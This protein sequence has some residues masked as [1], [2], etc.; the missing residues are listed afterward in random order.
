ARDQ[1]RVSG[2]FPLGA[3]E[4]WVSTW[5]RASRALAVHPGL[6]AKRRDLLL[7]RQVVADL[8][9]QLRLLAERLFERVPDSL[10]D[11]QA[12]G[13]GEVGSGGDRV[14]VAVVERIV[15]LE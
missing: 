11:Q 9:D 7:L 2:L 6:A 14:L 8:V 4:H 15:R 3:L 1:D 13:N 10:P 5:E 12:V